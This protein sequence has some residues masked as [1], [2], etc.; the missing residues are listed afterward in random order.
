MKIFM[1]YIQDDIRLDS[2]L[3]ETFSVTLTCI[4]NN[5]FRQTK[6]TT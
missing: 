5:Y 1:Y 2:L 6:L 3:L 4:I